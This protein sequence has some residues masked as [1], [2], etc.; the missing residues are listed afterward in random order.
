RCL[1][2]SRADDEVGVE[3]QPGGR[4]VL[5]VVAPGHA[6]RQHIQPPE[7][8]QDIPA[9]QNAATRHPWADNGAQIYGEV[10]RPPARHGHRNARSPCRWSGDAVSRPAGYGQ[11]AG[12]TPSSA[13]WNSPA[14]L[15][16]SR[17]RKTGSSLSPSLG[18]TTSTKPAASSSWPSESAS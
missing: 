16:E 12:F 3:D 18:S 1:V 10:I 13:N 17:S 9:A 14:S 2:G 8:S 7:S 11:D 15:R 5:L 4:A 6:S